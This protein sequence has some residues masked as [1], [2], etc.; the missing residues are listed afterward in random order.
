[1]DKKINKKA[2]GMRVDKLIKDLNEVEDSMQILFNRNNYRFV[3]IRDHL[4]GLRA[5]ID[6]L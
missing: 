4:E 6:E 2:L 1:M 5:E 3:E